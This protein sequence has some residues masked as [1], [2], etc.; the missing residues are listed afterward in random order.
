MLTGAWAWGRLGLVAILG[1]LAMIL[2]ICSF[3]MGHSGEMAM[4][5]WE[6]RIHLGFALF[7]HRAKL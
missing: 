2:L 6:H 3:L 5:G 7:V 1:L 4:W